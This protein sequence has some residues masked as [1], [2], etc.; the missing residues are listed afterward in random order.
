MKFPRLNSIR[1]IL[2]VLSLLIPFSIRFIITFLKFDKSVTWI[3]IIWGISCILLLIFL[4]YKRTTI[5]FGIKR[6]SIVLLASSF[7]LYILFNYAF[8]SSNLIQSFKVF[9]NYTIFYS[10]LLSFICYLENIE[11]ILLGLIMAIVIGFILKGLGL[12][13]GGFIISFSFF[14]SSIGYFRLFIKAR[15]AYKENK[16]IRRI[17]RIFFCVIAI[18]YFL[19][20]IFFAASTPREPGNDYA[21]GVIIFLLACLA[22]FIFMPFS[23]FID[24]S[25]LQKQ[26]FKRLILLPLILF[27]F[28]FS[29]TYLLPENTYNK[30]FFQNYFG[31]IK[32]FGKE[33]NHFNMKDYTIDFSKK[34]I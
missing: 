13:E 22:L 9:V 33:K 29:L 21:P 12:S 18:L 30:I 8:A 15:S 10:I 32:I 26:T 25:K 27:F 7:L 1:W 34:E 5:S 31:K 23:N 3:M 14:L 17:F 28:I 11:V 2:V 4:T 16:T 24:W 19:L 6:F 20:L